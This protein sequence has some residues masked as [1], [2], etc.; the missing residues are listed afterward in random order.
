MTE[1]PM[2]NH[3]MIKLDSKIKFNPTTT[4]NRKEHELQRAK[5]SKCF[6]GCNVGDAGNLITDVE[7]K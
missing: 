3:I 6:L 7:L 1:K 2:I 4:A 5:I